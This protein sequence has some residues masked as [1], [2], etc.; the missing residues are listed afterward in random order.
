ME[1]EFV[2]DGGGT[3]CLGCGGAPTS[4]V[5][6]NHLIVIIT[7]VWKYMRTDR[8][9][10]LRSAAFHRGGDCYLLLSSLTGGEPAV[11]DGKAQLCKSLFICS[12]KFP[13]SELMFLFRAWKWNV[14]NEEE[15]DQVWKVVPTFL[16]WLVTKLYIKH[17]IWNSWLWIAFIST[18]KM[19]GINSQCQ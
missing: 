2:G 18:L 5:S 4:E 14:E 13:I 12:Y 15:E 3:R 9:K 8:I 1:V 10:E 17:N 16:W 19:A 7:F 6:Y 11:G